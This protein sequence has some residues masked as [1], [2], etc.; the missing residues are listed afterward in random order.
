M[1]QMN[2]YCTFEPNPNLVSEIDGSRE[3]L[4]DE[5]SHGLRTLMLMHVF[6]RRLTLQ[7]WLS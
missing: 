4:M 2:S 3:G 1:C 5:T 7:R 6:G